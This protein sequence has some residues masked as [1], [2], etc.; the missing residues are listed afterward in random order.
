M[1]VWY[2]KK[3]SYLHNFNISPL[4]QQGGAVNQIK[5]TSTRIKSRIRCSPQ[6][7]VLVQ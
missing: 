2:F 5:R 6:I 3:T 1:T 7:D 4:F